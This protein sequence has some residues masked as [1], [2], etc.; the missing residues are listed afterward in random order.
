MKCTG[1]ISHQKIDILCPQWCIK[2]MFE[3]Y[4]AVDILGE[5]HYH[6]QFHRHGPKA[7]CLH[8]ILMLD[9]DK[10][11]IDVLLE[12]TSPRKQR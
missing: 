4:V 8:N 11:K 9:T 2:D 12:Q 7:E 1:K 3:N 5:G 6:V 10:G